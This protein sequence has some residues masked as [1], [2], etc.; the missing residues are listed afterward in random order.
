MSKIN[1]ERMLARMSTGVE[2]LQSY[3]EDF[4]ELS[5]AISDDE[6]DVLENLSQTSQAFVEGFQ[7]ALK[8]AF[9]EGSATTVKQKEGC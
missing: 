6:W 9:D 1:A 8:V 7:R 3:M 2:G 4:G 5:W